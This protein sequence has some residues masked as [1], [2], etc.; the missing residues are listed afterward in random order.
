MN[1]Q[2]S[3]TLAQF[4]FVAS[5][6]L[7]HSQ[8]VHNDNLSP[9][10]KGWDGTKNNILYTVYSILLLVK[11]VHQLVLLIQLATHVLRV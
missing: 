7:H 8:S 11:P 5:S 1:V 2:C 10:S 6:L 9:C 4:M 3:G